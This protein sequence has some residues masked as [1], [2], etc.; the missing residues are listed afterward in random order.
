M[1]TAR[2]R[3][4]RAPAAGRLSGAARALGWRVAKRRGA[5]GVRRAALERAAPRSRTGA[6]PPRQPGHFRRPPARVGPLA[7]VEPAGVEC[8]RGSPLARRPG[9]APTA[10]TWPARC[11]ACRRARLGPSGDRG[12]PPVGGSSRSSPHAVAAPRRGAV[13]FR[14]PR[15]S[16]LCPARRGAPAHRCPP[17]PTRRRCHSRR[18]LLPR[19]AA[20]P[21][22]QTGRP[23]PPHS[24]RA[25]VAG[26]HAGARA[27]R[28][29]RHGAGGPCTR[30]PGP[31]AWGAR[32]G[33]GGRP[34][35]GRAPAAPARCCRSRRAQRH[36]HRA[37]G[38]ARAPAAGRPCTARPRARPHR[39]L[40]PQQRLLPR[41]R[42]RR[43]RGRVAA[44]P[45][46][47][48]RQRA[49]ARTAS[50]ACGDV[51]R[52]CQ[53]P[54]P[55]RRRRPQRQHREAR[56]VAG[57]DAVRDPRAQLDGRCTR[58]AGAPVAPVSGPH[59]AAAPGRR[60]GVAHG[61]RVS[62]GGRRGRGR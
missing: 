28:R 59:G 56:G 26:P 32:V 48:P 46:Q 41:R 21:A 45:R 33:P 13:W 1:G 24:H 15:E 9:S 34:R 5:R 52:V 11:Q 18:A 42:S 12:H 61:R 57:A 38:G 55:R 10:R 49:S 62:A 6:G 3:G 17:A 7:G 14:G 2:L 29:R 36:M 30:C 25:A 27:P 35:A 40:L 22:G 43:P 16:V 53:R 44:A 37:A 31:P 58:H 54:P 39:P 23:R 47:Q 50:C 51:G 8:P 60:E 20:A 19:A 4:R